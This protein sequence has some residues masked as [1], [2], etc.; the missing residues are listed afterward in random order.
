[1]S[2]GTSHTRSVNY[3]I[4]D[5]ELLTGLKLK[6]FRKIK[7]PE[8]I[9]KVEKASEPSYA[10][11]E[12]N[13]PFPFNELI[14]SVSAGL[15]PKDVL[16]P[17]VEINGEK[18]SC[19]KFSPGASESLS[20]KTDKALM[21]TDIL[22]LRE[23]ACKLKVRINLYN[24]SGSTNTIK[25]VNFVLTDATL[26]YNPE[27]AEG[28]SAKLAK[29]RLEV[30]PI[31]QM[32]QQIQYSRDI[33]SPTSLAML[34]NFYGI[35][36]TPVEISEK[37]MDNRNGIYGNWL[38]NTM[39][40]STKNLYAFV[41]RLNTV[42]E[43]AR[44]LELGIPVIASITFGPDELKN[45]PLKKT[46]GHLVLIKGLDEK[47]N[48]IVNDPAAPSDARV[49]TVYSRKEFAAAW[50]KNKFGTSYIIVKDIKKL[51][52]PAFPYSELFSVKASTEEEKRKTIE[53]QVLP[54]ERISLLQDGEMLKVE[55]PDQKTTDKNKKQINYSGYLD[56]ADFSLPL[57]YNAMVINKTADIYQQDSLKGPARISMGTKIN[58][59]AEI[60]NGDE[61]LVLA[62]TGNRLF[63]LKKENISY[64]PQKLTGDKARKEVIRRARQFKGDPYYW[65]GRSSFGVDCSG[66]VNLVYRTIGHELARNATDQFLLARFA[67]PG[68]LK[69]GDLIFS[70]GENSSSINHVMIY[71]GDGNILESTQDSNSVREIPFAE[72]FGL[73]LKKAWNGQKAGKRKIYFR[74]VIPP[75]PAQKPTKRK[76]AAAKKPAHKSKGKK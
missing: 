35:K 55:L 71:A 42:E 63:K 33:C 19:G 13:S 30:P 6:N 44:Y 48:F 20:E 18:F 67:S 1:M 54:D 36:K 62:Q 65:G 73:D 61:T 24:D 17:S 47:G 72:K 7:L 26:P 49:E 28:T 59:V 2:Q 38:F 21:D 15:S 58:A 34:L 76:P 31:S 70:T 43:A 25:L 3:F 23:K 53:T 9:L 22:R 41:A 68:S 37:V 14:C 57:K 75:D 29:K 27:E 39:Y 11:F 50:L 66:L 8:G 56:K 10:E 69:P 16:E 51:S 52:T 64:L 74:S 12:L 60:K 46:A 5:A 4:A 45:S 40:A 32:A